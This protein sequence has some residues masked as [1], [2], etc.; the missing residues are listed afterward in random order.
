MRRVP[1]TEGTKYV[2]TI[3]LTAD[4][5]HFL[6]NMRLLLAEAAASNPE[7]QISLTIYLK[8]FSTVEG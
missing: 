4:P 8:F 7:Q 6:I 5:I 3:N 1:L 2:T